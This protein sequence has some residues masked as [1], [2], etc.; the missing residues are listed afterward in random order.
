MVSSLIGGFEITKLFS[1]LFS[2]E[3]M[4]IKNKKLIVNAENDLL[5]AFVIFIF[6]I[7]HNQLI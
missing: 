6:F 5:P 4:K 3:L 2:H 1:F 7:L